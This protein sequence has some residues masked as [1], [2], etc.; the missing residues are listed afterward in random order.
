MKKK[1]FFWSPMLSHVGTYQAVIS[2][3]EALKKFN[4]YQVFLINVFG[5]F[6]EYEN[7]NIEKINLL[8]IKK[9]IPNKGN[10][11]KLFYYSITFALIPI[12]YYWVKKK[13][14]DIIIANLVGY[15]PNILKIFTNIKVINSIQGFP[16]F[17]LFRK[18]I[19]KIFYSNSDH[20][21]TM[22]SLTKEMLIENFDF[23][24]EK[25]TKIDNPIISKK[26]IT[27]SKHEI[28]NEDQLIFK[29]D[30]FCSIGRLTRQ[31]NFIELIKGFNMFLKKTKKD[32]NLIII[33]DGEKKRELTKYIEE[34][35][36]S[37]CYL[38]G[39]KAN[40]FK[41]LRKSKLFISTSLWEEPGHTLIEAGFLNVPIISSCCPN[42]P[43]EFIK[44]NIN[45]YKYELGSSKNLA[46][47]LEK[48]CMEDEKKILNVKVNFKKK[49]VKEFTKFRFS[50]KFK[51]ILI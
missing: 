50:K 48:F 44:D 5:E 34:N 35:N 25:I 41:Y 28:E 51:N 43:K 1:I 23:Q 6:D 4:H 12:L 17:N 15:I 47:K 18:I 2:M 49:I 11:S 32:I 22:S 16:R 13:K 7:P 39:F 9:Y 36:I 33:G 8:R 26:I 21:I 24:K 29:K 38:L 27:Y 14:P 20:F 31:K 10:I 45:S 19:W 37:N 30:V 3:S 42:G 46:E 40:P